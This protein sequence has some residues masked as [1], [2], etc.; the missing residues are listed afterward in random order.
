MRLT[1]M[2]TAGNVLNLQKSIK[3]ACAVVSKTFRAV[4]KK[5]MER[6]GRLFKQMH[7]YVRGAPVCLLV[8]AHCV[9]HCSA[10]AL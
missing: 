5:K 3:R 7:V 8:V 10:T 2:I 9:A 6:L 4:F 1:A